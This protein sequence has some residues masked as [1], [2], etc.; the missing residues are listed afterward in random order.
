MEV[1]KLGITFKLARQPFTAPREIEQRR[2]G[3]AHHETLTR[4]LFTVYT[5]LFRFF[6]RFSGF[7]PLPGCFSF[8]CA[9][10]VDTSI[11]SLTM[12]SEFEW[13]SIS[14]CL[15]LQFGSSIYAIFKQAEI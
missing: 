15:I 7:V 9:L 1:G 13:N 3:S 11:S 6:V 8:F 5:V 2:N 4:I 12:F 14:H 10:C